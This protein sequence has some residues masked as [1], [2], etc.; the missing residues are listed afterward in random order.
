MLPSQYG[1]C[2]TSGTPRSGV[3]STACRST[4]PALS[5]PP[6]EKASTAYSGGVSSPTASSSTAEVTYTTE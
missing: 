6:E 4:S 3:S 1:R 2:R 5:T